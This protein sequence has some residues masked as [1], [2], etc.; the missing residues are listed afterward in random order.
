MVKVLVTGGGGFIGSHLVDEL[1]SNGYETVILDTV[2]NYKNEKAEY[3]NGSILDKKLIGNI[4]DDID[5][6]YHLAASFGH[7]L[8]MENPIMDME[9]NVR[10]T[11]NL[12]E[13]CKNS[14]IKRIVYASSSAIFGDPK[15]FPINENSP[16]DPLTPYSVSKLSG[17]FYTMIYHQIYNLP[18]TSIRLFNIYGPREYPSSYRGVTS[19][20]LFQIM[21]GKSIKIFGSGEETRTLTFVKDAAQGF[22]KAGTNKDAVGECFNIAGIKEVSVNELI[23]LLFKVTNKR[24]EIIHEK[25]RL[26]ETSR[27]FTSIEK[28]K[29]ILGYNPQYDLEKGLGLAYEWFQENWDDIVKKQKNN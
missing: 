19:R 15:E 1:Q 26:G 12:L 28:S 27:R 24:V 6:V 5:I 17:E 11:L 21:S 3:I 25:S 23:E 7:K 18:A 10:G 22:L 14:S 8:S 29:R 2:I 16:L 9:I 20:F 13:M 4:I